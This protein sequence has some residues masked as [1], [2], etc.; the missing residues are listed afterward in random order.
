MAENSEGSVG[1]I[2]V[3]EKPFGI[4]SV[5]NFANWTGSLCKCLLGCRLKNSIAENSV[6]GEEAQ[7]AK[8]SIRTLIING[9]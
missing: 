6:Y 5:G 3:P 4:Q 7:I 9:N 1:A 2:G 8:S